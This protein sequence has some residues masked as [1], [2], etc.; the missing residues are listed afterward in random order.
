MK[1]KKITKLSVTLKRYDLETEKNHNYFANGVLVHNCNSRIGFINGKLVTGSHTTRKRFPFQL[2]NPVNTHTFFHRVRQ[3]IGKILPFVA[4]VPK[5]QD[6][7]INDTEQLKQ[8]CFWY[9]WTVSGVKELL[10]SLSIKHKQVILF[11]E[12]AGGSVQGDDMNYGIPKGTG[13]TYRAFDLYLDGKYVDYEVFKKLCDS[14]CVPRVP[15]LYVGPWKPEIVLPMSDG[16]TT[17]ANVKHIREGIVVKTAKE[18]I[19][20]KVGRVILKF[21]GIEYQLK[22]KSDH[23]GVLS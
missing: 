18:R 14:F 12:I 15:E 9:P 7:T 16:M 4:Y 10:E 19:H 17:F 2:L 3:K 8:N 23:T 5:F 1:L 11:G 21:I 22:K 6:Y 13:Y 20:R